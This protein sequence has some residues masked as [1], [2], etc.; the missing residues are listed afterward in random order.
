MDVTGGKKFFTRGRQKADV[1]DPSQLVSI[2]ACLAA[3]QTK[4]GERDRD[5]GQRLVVAP[6]HRPRPR[7]GI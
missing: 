5:P 4:Y 7:A 3:L 1:T 2:T 6:W